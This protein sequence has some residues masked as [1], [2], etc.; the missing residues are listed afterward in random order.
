MKYAQ[1]YQWLEVLPL[2]SGEYGIRCEF[3]QSVSPL[4]GGERTTGGATAG[5]QAPAVPPLV[6]GTQRWCKNLGH[7]TSSPIGPTPFAWSH[8][9][10][11]VTR[12]WTFS[13]ED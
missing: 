11:S 12:L 7:I 9:D 8:N 3:C 6:K 4:G 1:E 10:R 13:P 2:N 5:P